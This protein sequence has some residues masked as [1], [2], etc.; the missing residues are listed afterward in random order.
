[1]RITRGTK[2]RALVVTPTFMCIYIYIYIYIY[3]RP[4]KDAHNQ[5]SAP[6]WI[7]APDPIAYKAPP[8]PEAMLFENEDDPVRMTVEP[9]TR[10]PAPAHVDRHMH[11]CFAY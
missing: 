6:A 10:N 4:Q 7:V 5:R 2:S 8:D 11:Y 9:T 3:I 1:M